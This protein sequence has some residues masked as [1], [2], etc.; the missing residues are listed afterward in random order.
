MPDA[1]LLS[2][3]QW[4]WDSDALK[5]II[6]V[7]ASSGFEVLNGAWTLSSIG[8]VLEGLSRRRLYE[9][10]T[11]PADLAG[12]ALCQLK[13]SDGRRV[14]LVGTYDAGG[15]ARGVLMQDIETVVDGREDPGPD[16][17]PVFQ[18][19]LALES[20]E[21]AGF[22][23]LARWQG[24]D[25]RLAHRMDRLQDAGL[26]PV[27]LMRASEALAVWQKRCAGK[28]LFVNVNLTAQDL[29]KDDLPALVRDLV[30][31]HGFEPG[32]LRIE[33][34][35]QAALRDEKAALDAA[36]ALKAAGAGLILDDF[37]SG[38]S[39]FAWL[40]ALPADGLKVD[41]DLI[42]RLSSGR[43]K[44]ILG[45]ITTLAAELGMSSTAE[46]VEQLEDVALI[47]RLGFG[48]AQGF[49]FARPLSGEDAERLLTA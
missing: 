14:R 10:L 2:L 7:E 36:L 46:G 42:A 47:R 27:M 17:D 43:M 22:E 32:Q 48:Y 6:S 39:S 26:A 41:A 18:P 33:L 20:G 5:L 31:G 15:G 19:I 16:I 38:H 3:G 21:I 25:G 35:E 28:A 9:L 49:A 44:A 13:L 40:E 30:D 4:R 34:T 37:G 24:A 45:S 11:E 29:S 23:A 8:H 1:D 12:P